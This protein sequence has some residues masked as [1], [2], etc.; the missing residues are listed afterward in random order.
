MTF[1]TIYGCT[2]TVIPIITNKILEKCK[3]VELCFMNQYFLK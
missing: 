2:T 3:F 1:T